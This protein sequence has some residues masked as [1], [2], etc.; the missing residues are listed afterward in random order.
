[1][2]IFNDRVDDAVWIFLK[3]FNLTEDYD[4]HGLPMKDWIPFIQK[5]LAKM[6]KDNP[7]KAEPI[8]IWLRDSIFFILG[9][10]DSLP[11][12]DYEIKTSE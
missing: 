6:I 9:D 7:E 3:L 12:V 5:D 4:F 1:M 10:L 11:P 8:L 2:T